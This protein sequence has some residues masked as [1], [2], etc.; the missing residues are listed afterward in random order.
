MYHMAHVIQLSITLHSRMF[1]T[2]NTMKSLLGPS[3][4]TVLQCDFTAPFH[5]VP[6]M[7]SQ[8]VK[9]GCEKFFLWPQLW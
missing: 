6:Q 4:H 8:K 2:L 1:Q 5:P 3:N 7:S 9:K